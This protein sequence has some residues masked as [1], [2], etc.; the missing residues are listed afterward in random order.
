MRGRARL[1]RADLH[2]RCARGRR[3]ACSVLRSPHQLPLPAV[4]PSRCC[5]QAS[6]QLP[7]NWSVPR[8][9][10]QPATPRQCPPAGTSLGLPELSLGIIPGFGGTQRLPRAVGVQAAAQLMLTSRPLR[11]RAAL[12][13]G[14]VDQVVPREQL[15]AAARRLALDIAGASAGVL[16]WLG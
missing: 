8:H 16:G 12:K 13:A 10:S 3:A 9:H 4:G 1:Q 6:K 11:D 5:K 7:R 14:L 2:S 15:M